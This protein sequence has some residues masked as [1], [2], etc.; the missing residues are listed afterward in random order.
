MADF[1]LDVHGCQ[2]QVIQSEMLIVQNYTKALQDVVNVVP[3]VYH[4]YEE[5]IL[6]Q[7][8]MEQ[9]TSLEGSEYD[10]VECLA[11]ILAEKGASMVTTI[12]QKIRRFMKSQALEH[13]GTDSKGIPEHGMLSKSA[14]SQHTEQ[15]PLGL[16]YAERGVE[17]HR[18]GVGH[19]G[20]CRRSENGKFT[21]TPEVCVEM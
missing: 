8:E 20:I 17:H 2:K 9:L 5:G 21:L 18:K 12:K 11:R 13:G 1:A 10:S 3:I 4:L 15:S 14:A 7:S 16:E 19:A 6:N